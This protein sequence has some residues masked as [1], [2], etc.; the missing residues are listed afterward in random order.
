MSLSSAGN[1]WFTHFINQ[2]E[3]ERKGVYG[4]TML[5]Y[6]IHL[7]KLYMETQRYQEQGG[8]RDGV[9]LRKDQV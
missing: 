9:S 1:R 3:R 5:A 8:G 2:R 4:V 7:T 6:R